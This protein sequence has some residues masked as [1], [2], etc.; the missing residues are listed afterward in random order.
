MYITRES[1]CNKNVNTIAVLLYTSNFQ[2]AIISFGNDA[3]S[4]YDNFE[5]MTPFIDFSNIFEGSSLLQLVP[6]NNIR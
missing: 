1:L 2:V 4:N 6:L 5:D 3:V